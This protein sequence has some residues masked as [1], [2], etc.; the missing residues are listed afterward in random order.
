VL[1]STHLPTADRTLESDRER[2]TLRAS[3]TL[4]AETR[5]RG[6]GFGPVAVTS[7]WGTQSST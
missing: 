1:P 7:R 6:S 2:R 5:H 3:R 4:F